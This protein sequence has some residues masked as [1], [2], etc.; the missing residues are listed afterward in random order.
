[1][2]DTLPPQMSLSE[3]RTGDQV[4]FRITSNEQIFQRYPF[5]AVKDVNEQYQLLACRSVRPNSWITEPTL[6]VI[7]LAK[8]AAAVTDTMGNLTTRSISYLPDDR[9]LDNRDSAYKETRG[10]WTS[11]TSGASWSNEYRSTSLGTTDS[12]SVCW[13]WQT[14]LTHQYNVFI[15]VPSVANPVGNTLLRRVRMD[16]HRHFAAGSGIPAAA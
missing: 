7:Q 11:S 15:Q 8:A 12:A 13:Q 14:A 4:A 10:T 9:F 3:E 6:P 2:T 1:M 16:L 5:V